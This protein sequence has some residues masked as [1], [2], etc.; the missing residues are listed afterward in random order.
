MTETMA[1]VDKMEKIFYVYMELFLIHLRKGGYG[2]PLLVLEDMLVAMR[3][4]VSDIILDGKKK[5]LFKPDVD[6]KTISI[7]L[8]ASLDGVALHYVMDKSNFD[9]KKI[10]KDFMDTFFKGLVVEDI[11]KK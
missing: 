6:H 5:G 9:T 11:K 2:V 1:A 8:V 7:F 4:L 3:K 10:C